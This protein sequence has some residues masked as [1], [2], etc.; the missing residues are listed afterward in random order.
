MSACK[1]KNYLNN[2]IID[3]FNNDLSEKSLLYVTNNEALHLM[4]VFNH[5]NTL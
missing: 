5:F 4:K 1:Q 3:S 2:K